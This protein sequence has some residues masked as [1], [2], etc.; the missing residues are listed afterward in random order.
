MRDINSDVEN[1][2]TAAEFTRRFRDI[3]SDPKFI[4]LITSRNRIVTFLLLVIFA[5]YFA[6]LAMVCWYPSMVARPLYEGAGVTVGVAAE[7]LLFIVFLAIS[8]IYVSFAN[9]KFDALLSSIL[10]Q[11]KETR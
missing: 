8:A 7:L 2:G 1:S 3:H 9:K 11:G 5:G 10:T 6:F 4:R